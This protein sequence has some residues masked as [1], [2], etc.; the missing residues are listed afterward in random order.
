VPL[1]PT[2]A[3]T[4]FHR[5][6]AE[7]LYFTAVLF[8]KVRKKVERILNFEKAFHDTQRG[9]RKRDDQITGSHKR[10]ATKLKILF[11]ELLFLCPKFL[12]LKQRF[13]SYLHA[14]KAPPPHEFV[15]END[16]PALTVAS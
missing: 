13:H 9:S 11:C 6:S 14:G 16:S 5:F 12:R 1:I 7:E 8:A 10:K 15:R 2:K 3:A 4:I